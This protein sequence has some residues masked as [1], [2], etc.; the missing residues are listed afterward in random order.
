MAT[1]KEQHDAREQA[2]RQSGS[3]QGAPEAGS[4]VSRSSAAPAGA[5]QQ[6]DGQP[7]NELELH[8]HSSAGQ[9]PR[10]PSERGARSGE[11][12]PGRTDGARGG[13]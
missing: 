8:D 11:V 2:R 5:E 13:S 10:G 7:E 12:K 3:G 1:P 9:A 6:A 4:E